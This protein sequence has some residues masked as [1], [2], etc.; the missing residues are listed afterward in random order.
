MLR[1]ILSQHETTQKLL[2]SWC[3]TLCTP[4]VCVFTVTETNCYQESLDMSATA[5]ALLPKTSNWA[6][7]VASPYMQG[8]ALQNSSSSPLHPAMQLQPIRDPERGESQMPHGI[9][10][11]SCMHIFLAG[12]LREVCGVQI[13]MTVTTAVLCYV[14]TPRTP[15]EHVAASTVSLFSIYMH[16]A[17]DMCVSVPVLTCMSFACNVCEPIGSVSLLSI[18]S[19]AGSR[20]QGVNYLTSF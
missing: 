15:Q 14:A 20:V 3:D 17:S 12:L 11:M 5:A 10:G 7:A 13:V 16:H 18:T 8:L 2:T 19:Q 6:A 1:N 4:N 9:S